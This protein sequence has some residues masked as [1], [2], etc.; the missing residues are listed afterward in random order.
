MEGERRA[1]ETARRQMAEGR[2]YI[3][4]RYGIELDDRAV[5]A[6]AESEVGADRAPA[7]DLADDPPTIRG[8]E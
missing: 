4:D 6:L 3:R 5:V 7:F 2:R 1:I 8:A